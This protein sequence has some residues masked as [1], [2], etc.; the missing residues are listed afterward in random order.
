MRAER[1]RVMVNFLPLRPLLRHRH[2]QQLRDCSTSIPFASNAVLDSVRSSQKSLRLSSGH[3]HSAGARILISTCAL[4]AQSRRGGVF[5]ADRKVLR[6]ISSVALIGEDGGSWRGGRIGGG[7]AKG[8][9]KTIQLRVQLVGCY[10]YAG[11]RFSDDA[12]ATLGRAAAAVARGASRSEG[13]E[14]VREDA[15]EVRNLTL[16]VDVER[17][18][19]YGPVFHRCIHCGCSSSRPPSSIFVSVSETE[20]N[21]RSILLFQFRLWE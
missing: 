14:C 20:L 13:V 8:S 6:K 17:I 10:G 15:V 19:F 2:Q 3:H 12:D 4:S 11:N 21:V 18:L 1:R 5:A 7:G 9:N 16:S